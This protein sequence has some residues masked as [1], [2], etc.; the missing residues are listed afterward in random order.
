MECPPASQPK[1]RLFLYPDVLTPAQGRA[2]GRKCGRAKAEASRCCLSQR[3]ARWRGATV[4][5]GDPE[6][7]VG[8][9]KGCSAQSKTS[10]WWSPPAR[11]FFSFFKVTLFLSDLNSILLFMLLQW[12]RSPPF[13][14]SP[15]F[16][17]AAYLEETSCPR[18][19][20]LSPSP[21]QSP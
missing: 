13:D 6:R 19:V 15:F 1:E 11:F 20:I 10:C 9:Q 18:K 7:A 21:A 2:P 16:K 14:L 17:V 4:E 12:F 5:Q 8:T 3:G